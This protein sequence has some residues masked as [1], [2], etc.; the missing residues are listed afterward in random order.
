MIQFNFSSN[1]KIIPFEPN[2]YQTKVLRH[3][4]LYKNAFIL[5]SRQSGLST[6]MVAYLL[7]SAISTSNT[8]IVVLCENQPEYFN[9]FIDL[10]L[11]IKLFLVKAQ[12][13]GIISFENGS[14]IRFRKY[15][16]ANKDYLFRG[17]STRD[18]IMWVNCNKSDSMNVVEHIANDP[19]FR[20]MPPSKMILTKSG[21]T[22]GEKETANRLNLEFV[23]IPIEPARGDEAELTNF[24]SLKN[25]MGE[26][27]F[28]REFLLQ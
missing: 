15:N 27:A 4:E 16:K 23:K 10:N 17:I 9:S 13:N 22:G 14:S 6:V 3:L 2:H 19:V 5:S 18:C 20:T 24:I 11:H 25:Q 26:F 1:S 7:E 8:H 12:N 21:F 28:N